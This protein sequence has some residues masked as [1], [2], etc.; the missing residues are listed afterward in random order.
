MGGVNKTTSVFYIYG[1]DLQRYRQ[2][3]LILI[4]K[5]IHCH[6]VSLNTTRGRLLWNTTPGTR[7]K[8]DL[9]KQLD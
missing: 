7:S 8:V 6:V 3:Y 5:V 9:G 2:T 1:N 4:S